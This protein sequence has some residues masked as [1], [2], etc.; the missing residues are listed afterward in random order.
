MKKL[1]VDLNEIALEM[2]RS[3]DYTEVV[4]LD[5][6]TGE[7]VS[8]PEDV[9]RAVEEGD[10]DEIADLADWEQELVETA[11]SFLSDKEDRYVSIPRKPSYE[12]YK[13]M[14]EFAETVEDRRLKEKLEIALDGKGAFGRLKNVLRNYPDEEER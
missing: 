12:A 4:V 6:D 14:A 2:E 13:L 5:T 11:D 8:V 3:E 7:V 1:H 10:E 9:M